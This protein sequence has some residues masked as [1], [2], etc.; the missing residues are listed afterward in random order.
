MKQVKEPVA[1]AFGDAQSD[2][3]QA[4]PEPDYT[5]WLAT[6]K[7]SI[8]IILTTLTVFGLVCSISLLTWVPD[9]D[10]W[11]VEILHH[12]SIITH[13]ILLPLVVM[14]ILPPRYRLAA[15]ITFSAIGIHLSAD[16]LSPSVAY[17][18]IW[19][20][21]PFKMSIGVFSKPWIALNAGFAFFFRLSIGGS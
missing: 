3:P 5:F 20:P 7:I 8:I 15:A 6:K 1:E 12:R 16:L 2:E 9:V 17:G 13:S 11:F 14:L 10:Q 4:A 18:A 19:L 21:E